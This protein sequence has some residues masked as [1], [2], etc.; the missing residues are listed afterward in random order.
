[1]LRTKLLFPKAKAG[2][3]TMGWAVLFLDCAVWEYTADFND[4]LSLFGT[5]V[6]PTSVEMSRCPAPVPA[7]GHQL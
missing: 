2:V 7:P 3:S 1:M 6:C 5:G 4:I